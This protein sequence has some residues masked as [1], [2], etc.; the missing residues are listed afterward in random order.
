MNSKDKSS[1]YLSIFNR[2]GGEG[3]NT[4]VLNDENKSQ[5]SDLLSRLVDN[6]NPL[7]T[8]FKDIL[9]WFLLTNSRILIL[10]EGLLEVYNNSDIIEVRPALEEELK[11]IIHN[12][13][14]FTRLKIKTKDN[15]EIILSLEKGKPYEGI[16]QVLHFIRSSNLESR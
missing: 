6:E 10:K 14:F 16:Y 3:D 2:K 8:Y 7:I 9:N 11:D 5:Y 15:E 12:K 4:K 1:V 13:E